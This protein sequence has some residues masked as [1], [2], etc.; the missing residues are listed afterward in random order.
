MSTTYVWQK[1]SARQKFIVTAIKRG[2]F[3]VVLYDCNETQFVYRRLHALLLFE[4]RLARS[5]ARV[6]VG[7]VVHCR[8]YYG[9]GKGA[10]VG[11]IYAMTILG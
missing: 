5:I 3:T 6:R 9:Y 1:G 2:I 11:H 4:R 7:Y 8:M 10:P